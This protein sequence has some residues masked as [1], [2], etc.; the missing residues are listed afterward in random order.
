MDAGG[1]NTKFAHSGWMV[2]QE[3]QARRRTQSAGCPIAKWRAGRLVGGRTYP[4]WRWET[5]RAEPL[6]TVTT[7]KSRAQPKLDR[8]N[9]DGGSVDVHKHWSAG[10]RRNQKSRF[11]VPVT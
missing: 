6:I 1:R 5:H 7:E 11:K 4:F 3:S 2:E 10:V 9:G 8:R